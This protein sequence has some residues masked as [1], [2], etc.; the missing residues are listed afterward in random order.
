MDWQ[1]RPK[2]IPFDFSEMDQEH[3]I[4]THH[5]DSDDITLPEGA[6]GTSQVNTPAPSSANSSKSSEDCWSVRQKIEMLVVS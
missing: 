5:Q 2:N 3:D 4:G 1:K 6:V